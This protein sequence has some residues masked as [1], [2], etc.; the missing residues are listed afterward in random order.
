MPF[1]L[2]F[3]RL[4]HGGFGF[5]AGEHHIAAG[6]VGADAGKSQRLAHRLQ[7]AHRQ[8]AGAAD[9]HRTQKGNEGGHGKLNC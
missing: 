8:L 7:L 3:Q 5:A 4:L 6:D 9:I 2:R 1:K